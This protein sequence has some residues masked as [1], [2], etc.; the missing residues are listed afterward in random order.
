MFPYMSLGTPWWHIVVPLSI[1]DV[2]HNGKD[3]SSFLVYS[4]P[5]RLCIL[6]SIL[7]RTRTRCGRRY[8]RLWIL[9]MSN[10]SLAVDTIFDH[11][12]GAPAPNECSDQRQRVQIDC[13]A[14]VVPNG[15]EDIEATSTR[16][17]SGSACAEVP[18]CTDDDASTKKSAAPGSSVA[19][20]THP[21]ARPNHRQR[22]QHR[23][24]RNV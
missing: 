7:V 8:A 5:P 24:R 10:G 21:R 12:T 4:R 9:L 11:P 3:H 17:P 2:R 20:P 19:T 1:L 18:G 15:W 16:Y 13:P 22:N 23:C 6:R 14:V